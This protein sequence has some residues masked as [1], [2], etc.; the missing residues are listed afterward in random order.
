MSTGRSGRLLLIDGDRVGE[1]ADHAL[2]EV[3]APRGARRHRA[4]KIM[5]TSCLV[6]SGRL[7]VI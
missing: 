2:V 7:A 1:E 6:R 4:S 5:L 3:A